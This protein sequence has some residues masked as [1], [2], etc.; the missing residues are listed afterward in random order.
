MTD[1]LHLVVETP[2]GS[3]NKYQHDPGL[4]A[5]KL[6]RFLFSS[7]VYP[8]DYGFFPRTLATD[9][10]PLDGLACVSEPTFPGC[11][12]PVK[13]VGMLMLSVD[14]EPD[15]KLICVPCTDPAWNHMESL[16]DLPEAL[17]REI[18]HFFSMYKNPL[19]MDVQVDGWRPRPAALETLAKARERYEEYAGRSGT[20]GRARD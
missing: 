9:G 3:S 7:I 20:G 2:Q 12:I 11:Y 13:V 16:D 8:G 5:I 19:G 10:D 15:E 4:N 1:Q 17:L 6:D 18:E 14:Q